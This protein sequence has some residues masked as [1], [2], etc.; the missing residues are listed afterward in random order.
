MGI[1]EQNAV[2]VAASIALEGRPFLLSTFAP[3]ISLRVAEQIKVML[4]Y[5]EAPVCLVGIASG[6]V[7]SILGQTHCCLEDIGLMN[8]IPNISINSPSNVTELNDYLSDYLNNPRPTYLRLTGDQN[9]VSDLNSSTIRNLQIK[10]KTKISGGVLLISTG[11]IAR[12]VNDAVESLK[13]KVQDIDHLNISSLKPLEKLSIRQI[14]AK[15]DQ[16]FTIEEH[17][18]IGGLGSIMSDLL[19]EFNLKSKLTKI[20]VQDTYKSVGG[21]Y[22]DCLVENGLDPEGISKKVLNSI[23]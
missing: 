16:I 19:I 23:S 13:S 14:I 5:D 11:S 21:S 18:T 20:G 22:F 3:F 1:S 6:L 10:S 12:Q 2:G 15:Y 9:L 17:N 7:Q 8:L 4:G